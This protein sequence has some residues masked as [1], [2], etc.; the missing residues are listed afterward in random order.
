MKKKLAVLLLVF[1]VSSIFASA[2]GGFGSFGR[3][4]KKARR[5]GFN[6]GRIINTGY[7]IMEKL[8]L[9]DEQQIKIQEVVVDAAVK[10]IP[11]GAELLVAKI[12]LAVELKKDDP[13][14]KVIN[15]LI[16]TSA[17]NL[18]KVAKLGITALIDVKK[19]LTLEQKKKFKEIMKEFRK[20][21]H[22]RRGHRSNLKKRNT[23][24]KKGRGFSGMHMK[25]VLD[26]K[27]PTQDCS[28]GMCLP[29]ENK[30]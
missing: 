29:T 8:D 24:M 2:F 7:R 4:G 11:V 6:F 5:G 10:I 9:T 28:S 15:P 14:I 26:D 20:E 19:L 30:K 23:H 17:D 3:S 25:K 18:K 27:K 16:D 22:S 13:D 1:F 21:R 12:K